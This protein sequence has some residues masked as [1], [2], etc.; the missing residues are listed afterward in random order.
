MYKESVQGQ[1]KGWVSVVAEVFGSLGMLIQLRAKR[2]Y[3]G[4]VGIRVYVRQSAPRAGG[5]GRGVAPF[6][7][8]FRVRFLVH[9]SV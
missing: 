4:R 2:M 9:V 3:R 7:C 8:F 1:G 6:R 5:G